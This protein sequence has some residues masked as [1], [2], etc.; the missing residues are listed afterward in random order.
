MPRSLAALA[1]VTVGATLACEGRVDDATNQVDSVVISFDTTALVDMEER[2]S[3]LLTEVDVL[4]SEAGDRVGPA[5]DSLRREAQEIRADLSSLAQEADSTSTLAFE[6]LDVR[7]ESMRGDL[8]RARFRAADEVED[9]RRLAGDSMAELEA[10]IDRL[11]ARIETSTDSL[12]GELRDRWA[13]L[14]GEL[15]ELRADAEAVARVSEEEGREAFAEARVGFARTV[16]EFGRALR[17][18]AA[19]LDDV[20]EGVS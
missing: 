5:L 18:I 8:I 20:S 17:A 16:A 19:E 4:A 10:E 3:E 13:G 15:V 1:L 2:L 11:G 7:L 9:F 12:P 14:Q 6:R